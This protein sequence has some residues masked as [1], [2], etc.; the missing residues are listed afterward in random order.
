MQS[1]VVFDGGVLSQKSVFC[2]THVLDER[3]SNEGCFSLGIPY[4]SGLTFLEVIILER[5]G[6]VIYSF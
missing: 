3:A 2:K 5:K 4:E 6:T 1:A